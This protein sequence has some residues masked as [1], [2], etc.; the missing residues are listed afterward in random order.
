MLYIDPMFE[1]RVHCVERNIV[2]RFQKVC[3]DQRHVLLSFWVP[4]NKHTLLCRL[5]YGLFYI[6]IWHTTKFCQANGTIQH[7]Q[8][9]LNSIQINNKLVGIL[10]LRAE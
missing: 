7:V 4:Q 6:V 1:I 10:K 2:I 8:D 3:F 9:A 5:C